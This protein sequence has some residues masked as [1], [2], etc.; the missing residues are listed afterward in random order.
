M[1]VLVLCMVYQLAAYAVFVL[2]SLQHTRA[3]CSA[4]E[5]CGM[6]VI[7]HA[8]VCLYEQTKRSPYEGRCPYDDTWGC[9]ALASPSSNQSATA[10]FS[11]KACRCCCSVVLWVQP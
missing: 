7:L 9:A 1:H 8:S 5:P 4:F 2:R 3:C 10:L 11:A 6:T